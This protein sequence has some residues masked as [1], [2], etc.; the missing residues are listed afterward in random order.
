MGPRIRLQSKH[1][2]HMAT[3][4]TT[5]TWVPKRVITDAAKLLA[6]ILF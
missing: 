6:Q 3:R 2:I 4:V 5:T 1:V